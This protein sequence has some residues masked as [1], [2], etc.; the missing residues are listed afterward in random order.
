[1]QLRQA[2]D[3]LF[4]GEFETGVRPDEV[5]WQEGESDPTLTRQICN[6][7]KANRTVARTVFDEDLGRAIAE[8]AGWPGTRIMIDNVIWKPPAARPLGYHQDNAYL[9]WFTPGEIVTCWIALDNTTEVG[10]TIEF[11]RGSHR[12]SLG[13]P[14][15]EFHGPADYRRPLHL[16]AASA[17]EKP[18]IA[19]V[20]VGAG[21]GSFH[22]G[23][24][25]HG[26]ADNRSDQPRRAVVLHAM[27]AD[28]EFVPA[29]LGQGIGPIYGRYRRLGDNTVD[30]NHFP[31][32]WRSDGYRTPGLDDY[33]KD[34]L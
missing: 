23:R 6:G 34:S 8:L 9:S 31:I 30:E 19:Y 24:I 17:G 14:T 18:E 4:R 12:W 11:A 13:D 5:N 20:E 10:G 33:L 3:A 26:S 29:N 22:H 16:A 1:M 27:P 28:V 2:F 15:E 21:G 32:L 25:W 7:W